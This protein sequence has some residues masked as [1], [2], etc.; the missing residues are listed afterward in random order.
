MTT[1]PSQSFENHRQII[2]MYLAAL[3]ILFINVL[4]SVY[5]LVRTPGLGSLIAVLVAVALVTVSLYARRFALRVQDRVI[6]LEMQSRLRE[7]LPADLRARIDDLSDRQLIALRFAGDEELPDLCRTVLSQNLT[8]QNVIK[9][10]I[11]HWRAD[12]LR[13]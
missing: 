9:K 1:A 8:D 2:P 5:A 13:A 7:L 12:H 11:K 10:M 6:R 4:W 3:G